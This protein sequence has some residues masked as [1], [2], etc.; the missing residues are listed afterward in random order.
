MKI[1]INRRKSEIKNKD[2]VERRRLQICQAATKLF[3]KNGYHRT[4]VKEIAK[5]SKISIGSLYDYIHNKEDI[6]YL[7]YEQYVHDLERRIEKATQGAKNPVQELRAALMAYLDTADL[8]QDYVLFFYQESKYMK[9]KD[10][11]DVFNIELSI[12]K[13][14][15]DIVKKGDNKYFSVK[16]PFLFSMFVSL[17]TCG[18]AIRRWNLKGYNA[19]TYKDCLIDFFLHGIHANAR[20]K[21]ANQPK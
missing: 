12:M 13:A 18:W 14:F 16:D 9:K 8:F 21:R 5:A 17:L 19:E 20:A 4:S 3:S 7:F 1:H 2:L 6:L 11:I 10:L 15:E